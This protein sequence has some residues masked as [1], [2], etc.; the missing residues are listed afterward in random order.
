MQL[1]DT[2]T[3]WR[4]RLRPSLRF[5]TYLI[6]TMNYSAAMQK[7]ESN[8]TF[9]RHALPYKVESPCELFSFVRLRWKIHK[10]FFIFAL[11][12]L[13]Y[14]VRL[15]EYVHRIPIPQCLRFHDGRNLK[16]ITICNELNVYV[17]SFLLQP[18]QRDV[19]IR[20]SQQRCLGKKYPCG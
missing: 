20:P 17:F 5:N 9:P 10:T 2:E 8:L 6:L 11:E 18:Q 1:L 14:I 7:N 4:V 19:S 16:K 15:N 12:V 13:F 3:C